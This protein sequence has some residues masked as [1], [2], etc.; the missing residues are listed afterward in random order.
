MPEET[1]NTSSR[2]ATV[3]LQ[4]NFSEE[5]TRDLE[6]ISILDAEI[7]LVNAV[8]RENANRRENFNIDDIDDIEL[9]RDDL[10]IS[11]GIPRHFLT[12]SWL[13]ILRSSATF[14]NKSIRIVELLRVRMRL[15]FLRLRRPLQVKMNTFIH[16]KLPAVFNRIKDFIHHS[17][18]KYFTKKIKPKKKLEFF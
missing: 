5:F 16:V 1:S 8:A 11:T 3:P 4:W 2:R 15:R 14:R 17:K 9:L 6:S 12:E 13:S 7:F 10:I 18:L